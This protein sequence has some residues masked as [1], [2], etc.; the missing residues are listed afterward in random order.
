MNG[1]NM[2]FAPEKI[3]RYG[4]YTP[5]HTHSAAA[6]LRKF[7]RLVEGDAG[8][9]VKFGTKAES[10]VRAYWK[11]E[12]PKNPP[13]C[14]HRSRE[15]I[16][17]WSFEAKAEFLNSWGGSQASF[18]FSPLPFMV[19]TALGMEISEKAGDSTAQ[20]I[21]LQELV[22]TAVKPIFEAMAKNLFSFAGIKEAA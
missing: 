3:S 10:V 9:L 6:S 13:L 17:G 11:Q 22:Q 16:A 15:T 7:G 21:K 14:N 4:A 12:M 5:K 19:I 1:I 2:P 8:S 18:R 20:G